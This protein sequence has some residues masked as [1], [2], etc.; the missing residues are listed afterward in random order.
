MGGAVVLYQN[1]QRCVMMIKWLAWVL[2]HYGEEWWLVVEVLQVRWIAAAD[3]RLLVGIYVTYQS[4]IP[5][6]LEGKQTHTEVDP[7]MQFDFFG[8]NYWISDKEACGFWEKQ[9]VLFSTC[10]LF[11]WIACLHV[12]FNM[13]IISFIFIFSSKF[14]IFWTF[15]FFDNENKN[16]NT[17][18]NT[19]SSQLI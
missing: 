16:Y 1:D 10:F 12:Q 18:V 5:T 14:L 8:Q 2:W 17:L 11:L 3:R 6:D 7:S 15:F 13:K 4:T 9:W 19:I